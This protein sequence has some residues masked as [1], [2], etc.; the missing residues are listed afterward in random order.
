M[1]NYYRRFLKIG[2]TF[3]IMAFMATGSAYAQ[4]GD[5]GAFLRAGADDATILTKEYLKPFPTG[6]GT[7]LNAGWN[8]EAAPKKKLGFSLQIR[9]SLALVPTSDQEF[10]ISTLN[11]TNM[12]VAPGNSSITPTIAGNDSPGPEMIVNDDSGN[13]ISRFNM[14]EGSGFA[15]VPAPT[16]QAS[17][18]LIKNT[19]VTVRYFPK[20]DISDFGSFGVI[21]GAIK[22]DITQWLPAGNVLPVDISL[23]AGFNRISVDGNL[24]VQPEFGSIPNDPNN[25]G[26]FSDQEVNTSTNSF[27]INALVGK[28]LPLISGYV[29]AGYQKSTFDLNVNGDYPVSLPLNRYEVITDPIGFSVDSESSVHLLGG[30][31]VKLGFLAIYGEA[32]LANYFTANA[33]IGLSFR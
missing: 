20:T 22:H 9:S 29:G 13:E 16:I 25:V 11:L 32:T 5:I 23:M 6:F 28:S 27:V 14:P 17:V 18:G 26:D 2:I 24:D 30:F 10:D 1:L 8:E 3:L 31:R 4:L 7:G 19:D 21:G 15:F 12:E 33:G